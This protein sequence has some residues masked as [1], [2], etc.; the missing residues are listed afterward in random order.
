MAPAL[1]PSRTR[2][3]PHVSRQ[4]LSG[5]SAISSLRYM[6]TVPAQRH[7]A[8]SVSFSRNRSREMDCLMYSEHICRGLVKL[9]HTLSTGDCL[10]CAHPLVSAVLRSS[11]AFRSM[12]APICLKMIQG[13]PT[14]ER[15]GELA[16]QSGRVLQY[17]S[18]YPMICI[19]VRGWA[20]LY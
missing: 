17:S 5:T 9:A 6:S 7:G 11:I 1:Q 8:S 12:L 15:S 19:A 18:G 3:A 16:S 20:L 10:T 4:L 14:G 13:I 2:E